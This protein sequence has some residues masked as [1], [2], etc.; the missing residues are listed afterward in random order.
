LRMAIDQ[1]TPL[2]LKE[3][4]VNGDDLQRLG[5]PAGPRLGQI[6]QTLLSHVLDDPTQNTRARLLALAQAERD[7][8]QPRRRTRPA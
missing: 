1:Q 5:I 2:S 3:L 8:Q 4:A 6:L 7:L